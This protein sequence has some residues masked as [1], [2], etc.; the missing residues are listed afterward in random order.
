MD[1]AQWQTRFL[2]QQQATSPPVHANA[3][4]LLLLW[5][6]QQQW[7]LL[8]TRRAWHLRHH[9]GQISFPGG[10]IEPGESAKAAALRETEEEIGV[11]ATA[12]RLLGSLPPIATS[13][14]F[15]VSPWLGLLN[16]PPKLQLQADEVA[17]VFTLPLGYALSRQHQQQRWFSQPYR[18]Q[19]LYFLP[20]QGQLIWGATAAILHQLAEQ[21]QVP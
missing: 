12:I 17:E 6:E 9:P 8:L 18:Q 19:S 4:V 14:G 16:S 2:L 13:T 5:Q 3:A 10:R 21:L 7:Q 20:Y 1:T 15:V 11:P